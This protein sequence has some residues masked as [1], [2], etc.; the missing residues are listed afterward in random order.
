MNKKTV[1]LGTGGTIAGTGA[2]GGHAYTAAQLTSEELV[3]GIPGL[4][5]AAGGDLV[6]EEVA[7]IDS[8]DMDHAV[9]R[10]LA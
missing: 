10:R 8:K 7:R 9:W 4:A 6:I 3:R 5:Q 1:I 2:A